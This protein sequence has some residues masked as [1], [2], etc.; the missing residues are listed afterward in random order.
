V[1]KPDTAW[2]QYCAPLDATR[3]ADSPIGWL[4]VKNAECETLIKGM[5]WEE[6]GELHS[7]IKARETKGWGPGKA[8]EYLIP[9]LFELDG[10]RVRWPYDIKMD[11]QTVEQIDGAVEAVGLHCLIESKDQQKPLAIAPVAKMRNQ[12]LRRPAASIG[13]IFSMSG[14][15]DPAQVLAGYLG[16]QA[17]LLWHPEELVLALQKKRI[18]P[19]LEL[20]YRA[21]VEDGIHDANTAFLGAL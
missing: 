4:I 2:V 19:L 16:N 6:L 10:A 20:K 5:N 11:G 9:R 12:L 18:V 21:R 13:L 17:I 7:A 14:Y 1:A 15:T 8:F 3:G